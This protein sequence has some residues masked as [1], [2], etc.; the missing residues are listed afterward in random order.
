MGVVWHGTPEAPLGEAAPPARS[1][2]VDGVLR[3]DHPA[4]LTPGIAS[5]QCYSEACVFTKGFSERNQLQEPLRMQQV[6]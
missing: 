5:I 6:G 2:G 1:K 3:E 4:R